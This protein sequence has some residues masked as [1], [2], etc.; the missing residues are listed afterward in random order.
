MNMRRELVEFI[1]MY[2]HDFLNHLQ[3]I[4]GMAQ[5]DNPERIRGY[6]LEV[7]GRI[8]EINRIAKV[9]NATLA[10]SLLIFYGRA[11][12]YGVPILTA[13]HGPP[14]AGAVSE[15][16]LEAALGPVFNR[17][18]AWILPLLEGSGETVELELAEA[19]DEYTVSFVFP[20]ETGASIN[21]LNEMPAGINRAMQKI[22]GGSAFSIRDGD[23][24]L[25]LRLPRREV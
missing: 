23:A 9:G 25:I 20:V 5:L 22:G 10:A 1:D 18:A 21:G 13:F 6:V 2:G 7:T 16:D 19:K 4:S 8:R 3:V 12:R 15:A 24:R 14:V 11:A 17:L